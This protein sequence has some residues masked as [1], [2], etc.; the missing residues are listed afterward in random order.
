M[1]KIRSELV[2]PMSIIRHN[3]TIADRGR[4]RKEEGESFVI[5]NRFGTTK[6]RF[7]EG[8][9]AINP[10]DTKNLI[11]ALNCIY[12]EIHEPEEKDQRIEV[13]YQ[14]ESKQIYI[15][16]AKIRHYRGLKKDKKINDKIKESIL[17]YR[18]IDITATPLWITFQEKIEGHNNLSFITHVNWNNPSKVGQIMLAPCHE[19][20]QALL[21]PR[22]RSIFI[23]RELFNKFD[24][25]AFNLF[26]FI[27]SQ[28]LKYESEKI[29]S[30]EEL[31]SESRYHFSLWG[32]NKP[33]AAK[34][35]IFD[36]LDKLASGGFLDS[37]KKEN[38]KDGREGIKLSFPQKNAPL[39]KAV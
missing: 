11:A 26:L 10:S 1:K 21:A 9:A 33:R 12:D 39:E 20:I 19:I 6:I 29:F 15:N 18:Q 22:N 25:F 13:A 27:S 30:L 31:I 3:V 38:L 7:L 23:D 24:G 8:M 35:A 34:N 28:N 16:V 37:W 32:N 4:K 36:S 14:V 5:K 17:K 2:I